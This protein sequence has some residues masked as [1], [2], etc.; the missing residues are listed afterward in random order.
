MRASI[1]PFAFSKQI[2][3]DG[4]LILTANL[5]YE[6][7]MDHA[8]MLDYLRCQRRRRS[9]KRRVLATVAL[10]VLLLGLRWI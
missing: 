5:C 1:T 3:R 10:A 4:V 8:L 9:L 6:L 2:Y 7:G